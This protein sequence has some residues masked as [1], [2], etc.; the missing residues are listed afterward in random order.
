M[1]FS[2]A[3]SR[4]PTGSV[5][6]RIGQ[7]RPSHLMTTA[8][9]GAIADLPSMSVVVRGLDAWNPEQQTTINEPR[10]LTEVQRR[11]GPGIRALRTAPWDPRA[12]DDA[13]TRT[14]IPVTPFP[15]WVRCPRCYRL[16]S[17]YPSG[18]FELIHVSGRR[19]DLAKIVHK[20]CLKQQNTRDR[21]KRACVPARFLVACEKGHLD[22]FPYVDFVHANSTEPCAG[23]KLTMSDAASTLGPRVYVRCVECGAAR[24]I[25]ETSGSD[26]WEKLPVCRGRHPHLQRFSSCGKNLK[27][28]VLG[29]SNLWFNVSAS[30]LHLPQGQSTADLVAAEWDL[31]EEQPGPKAVQ[32]LIDRMDDLR[33]LREKEI[34]EVWAVIER[35]RAAGGPQ[36]GTDD[37]DLL[38]AE[39]DLL[40]HPTTEKQDEDFKATPTDTPDGYER[41]LTQVVQ[42]PRLREVTALLGFTRISA[43]DPEDARAA[44]VV[45]LGRDVTWLPAV[46]KRGE[47]IF[48]ELQEEAVRSWAQ[49]A[50]RH[51]RVTELSEAYRRWRHNRRQ[52]PDHNFPIAR[53]ALLHTLSH[54]LIRQVALECGYSSASLKERIYYGTPRSPMAGILLSTAASDSEGTLGGL[55]SLGKPIH[56]KRLLDQAFEDARL[57]SSDPLCAEHVPE[58]PSDTLHAAACHACL[59]ASETSCEANNRWLD[60]AL[61]VDLTHDGLAFEP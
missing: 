48:L 39:W 11:L 17:L 18:Q 16:G 28:M 21:N 53:Y 42:V 60:R 10:L 26:G 54:L 9:I 45:A 41:M 5:P 44:R 25:Q 3:S 37:G 50:S 32:R 57:C 24:N 35:F 6:T 27:L 33:A 1:A 49:R 36:T 29:A 23:P 52:P 8:G 61:L 14:G 59:F 12:A 31:F 47:G 58:D 51:E 19:P 7:V 22:D 4:P 20:T 30:A 46:E 2:S 43:T 56:L 55:V 15:G 34:T 38:S 40:S 13:W